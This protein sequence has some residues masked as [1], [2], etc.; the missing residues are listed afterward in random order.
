M[1]LSS[2]ITYLLY[3]YADYTSAKAKW[4]GRHILAISIIEVTDFQ[5]LYY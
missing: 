4:G 3:E 1:G 5:I 2:F